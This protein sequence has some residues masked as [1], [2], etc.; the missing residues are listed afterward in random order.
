[1]ELLNTGKGVKELREAASGCPACI[2]AALRQ[3]KIP[4]SE[5]TDLAFD[6]KVELDKFWQTANEERASYE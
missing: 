3:A 2:L 6:F 5:S 1:L 4:Y